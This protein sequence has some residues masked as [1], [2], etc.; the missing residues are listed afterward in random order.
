MPPGESRHA[1]A[2]FRHRPARSR[3]PSP[4]LL[5]A[6][7]ESLRTSLPPAPFGRLSECRNPALGGVEILVLQVSAVDLP[8]HRIGLADPRQYSDN[9]PETD[10]CKKKGQECHDADGYHSGAQ[11]SHD[12][13]LP[14]APQ[15][16]L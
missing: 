2:R 9:Q 14:V 3:K 13:H 7:A 10:N 12:D 1:G 4:P 6:V 15:Q 5:W 16:L 11:S 8:H